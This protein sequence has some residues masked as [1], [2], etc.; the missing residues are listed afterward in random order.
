[1]RDRMLFQMSVRWLG[2][3]LGGARM[4]DG[5]KLELQGGLVLNGKGEDGGIESWRKGRRGGIWSWAER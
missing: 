3:E 2:V 1:M 5:D 4:W